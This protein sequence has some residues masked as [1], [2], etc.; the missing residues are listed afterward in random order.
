MTND[1]LYHHGVMGMKWG[2][3]R[4]QNYDGSYTKKGVE[5]YKK[6]EAKYDEAH[7][8]KK[9][10]K[11]LYKETKKN[12]SAEF[13]DGSS[14]P[15]T[16]DMYK[17]TKQIEKDAKRNMSKKYDQVKRDYHGD[18]GKKL[19]NSGH[20]ITDDQRKVGYLATAAVGTHVLGNI[21]KNNGYQELA[22]ASYG[23][24]IGFAAITAVMEGKATVDASN[25]R[26]Y[27]THSREKDD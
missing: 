24:S 2:I 23:A 3:R 19:Y 26:A 7:A 15:V 16:K 13:P 5:H 20:T 18:K 25:L 1:E 22:A 14:M 11:R 12:G 6:A 27:Y 8:I 21:L 17:A 10:T 4:Y 9:E